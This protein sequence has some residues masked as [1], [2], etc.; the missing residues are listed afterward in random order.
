MH[1]LSSCFWISHTST[2]RRWLVGTDFGE[3][4]CLLSGCCRRGQ[5]FLLC[6]FHPLR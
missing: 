1:K 3:D 2:E 6:I 4:T 5:S